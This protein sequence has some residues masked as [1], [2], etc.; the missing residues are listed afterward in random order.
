MTVSENSMRA[1]LR[2]HA[3]VVRAAKFGSFQHTL[4]GPRGSLSFGMIFDGANAIQPSQD[5][6]GI[7]GEPPPLG[8]A[9]VPG[10][11]WP[12]S[13]YEFTM[14]ITD[15]GGNTLA[16]E[17]FTSILSTGSQSPS[18]IA[19]EGAGSTPTGIA[20]W[21]AQSADPVGDTISI[22]AVPSDPLTDVVEMKF[23]VSGAVSSQTLKLIV[24]N[25]QQ[26]DYIIREPDNFNFADIDYAIRALYFNSPV[27]VELRLNDVQSERSYG[28]LEDANPRPP[29][30]FPCFFSKL[31]DWNLVSAL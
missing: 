17:D 13:T 25:L 15:D 10:Q 1:T 11:G 19:V 31:A 3:K 12:D 7:P 26:R 28:L 22:P 2:E 18:I 9:A 6:K 30:A 27:G 16:A 29:K 5:L 14:A 23:I 20:H 21:E 4:Q 8:G 24:R